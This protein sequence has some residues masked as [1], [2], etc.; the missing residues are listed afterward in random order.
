[1]T[2]VKAE[3]GR[4]G[5]PWT[6]GEVTSASPAAWREAVLGEHGR[7][8]RL[9]GLFAWPEGPGAR[10]LV[11][12]LSFDRRGRLAIHRTRVP[13][14]GEFTS[15]TP[16]IPGAQAFEREIFEQQGPRP[17][18]HPWLKP[19]LRHE[20]P[21]GA[22]GVATGTF[23]RVEGDGVHEVAVGPVHAGIIEPGHFRF[24]CAGEEVIHLEI[25][26]GYQR[27]GVEA[28]MVS[29][30]PARRLALAESIA[31]DASVSHATAHVEAIEG[32]SGVEAPPR[33]QAIRAL[34]LEL[35]RLASH[36]G[37][38]GALCGDVG[39]LPGAAWLGRIRGD[40]LNLLLELSGNRL[41]RGLIVP[42]GV[43][44]DLDDRLRADFARRIGAATRDLEEVCDLAFS[45]PSVLSR[46]ER[47]GVLSGQDA[48]LL[49]V[50]GPAARAS[51]CSR[52]ARAD[53]PSG[54]YR[55]AHIAVT[56][57]REG[58]VMAR[59][60]VRRLEASRSLAFLAEEIDQ[61]P[62]GPLLEPPGPLRP[63]ALVITLV[64]GW[65]GETAHLAATDP[66]GSLAVYRVV[67]PSF[68]NWFALAVAMRGGQISDFP[69]CNKSFNLSY[70]GHDR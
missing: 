62:G 36:A 9:V 53:H 12:I 68:H 1:M 32:L 56:T 8:G 39:Y 30:S 25:H 23:F 29:A 7:G 47:T 69:L 57:A 41:G 66:E 26:L 60:M 67:D 18:G 49:G 61:L 3:P 22:T 63:D 40:F 70:A 64:E 34:A 24:Q 51:G 33:A 48:D 4:A 54:L 27:R 35:E 58:D 20:D 19:L 52:D 65:R 11:A 17:A 6:M 2:S 50:V 44:F 16:V 15:L 55:F 10:T 42:G 14:D 59:A 13:A 37:D 31:G 38:L 5:Q 45:E 28:L 43:R 21:E 46:F